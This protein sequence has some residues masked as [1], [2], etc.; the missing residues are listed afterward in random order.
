MP[1]L[2]LSVRGI[3]VEYHIFDSEQTA[4][5]SCRKA[6]GRIGW[7]L[8]LAFGITQGLCMILVLWLDR[9]APG[10]LKNSWV[11]LGAGT[12]PLYLVGMPLAALIM[13]KMPAASPREYHRVGLSGTV[14]FVTITYALFYV[15]QLLTMTWMDLLSRLTGHTFTMP[16]YEG[17]SLAAT[18]VIMGVLG[19]VMEELFFRGLVLRRLLPYGRV[20]SVVVSSALF[21]LFHGNFFQMFFAFGVGLAFAYITIRTGSM[22]YSV[23]LH[24]FFNSYSAILSFMLKNHPAMTTLGSVVILAAA[25]AGVILFFLNRKTIFYHL[26]PAPLPPMRCLAQGLK[27]VGLWIFVI[28]CLVLSVYIMI[29]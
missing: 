18:L 9:A 7:A 26:R 20:F 23:L 5:L 4:L 6:L 14:A 15:F 22:I 19:P 11:Y 21:G 28:L 13:W 2:F 16:S 1:A 27:A 29:V 3:M 25:V 12:L 10:S 17:E 8:A 24:I